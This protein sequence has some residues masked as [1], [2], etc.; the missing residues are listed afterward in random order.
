MNAAADLLIRLRSVLLVVALTLSSVVAHAQVPGAERQV[1]LHLPAQPM[2]QALKGLAQQTG[3]QLLF[4][5]DTGAKE[6]EA[7]ALE[8]TFTLQDAL[9]RLLEGSGL[10]FEFMDENTVAI[11]TER[12]AAES[13]HVLETVNVFATLDNALS[14]GSKSGQSLRETP[15]SVTVVTRERIEAQNLTS[16]AEALAQ[17]TGVT[18]VSHSPSAVDSYF[19]SRGFRVQTLQLDGGAPAYTGGFG[20]YLAPDTAEFDRIEMLRGVDGMFSG[21]GAPGGVVNLVRKRAQAETQLRANVSAGSWNAYRGE[22][23]VTGALTADGK[24]R[25]RLV[26]AYANKDYYY[27]RSESEKTLLFG[28]AEYDLAKA[29]Q[30]IVGASYEDRKEDAY[31]MQ[32][33]PRYSDGR[34]LKLSRSVAFNPDWARR[35]LTSREFFARVEHGYGSTGVV[36]LNLTRLEQSS[37]SRT[38]IAYGFID[39]VTLSGNQAIVRANDY[40]SVQD[41]LDL[42]A[43]GTLALF[44]R[45]HRYTL[46]VDYAQIDGGGEREYRAEGYVFPNG[47]PLDVFNFDPANFPEPVETLTGVYPENGQTQQGVYGALSLKL[48]ESLQL[49]LGGR[50][51]EYRFDQVYRAVAS[52]GT[53]GAPSATR[54]EASKF[55]PSAALHWDFSSRWS[56]YLSYAET[57]EAQ[58]NR[59]RA[60]TPGAVTPNEPID[61]VTG[62]GY[63]IGVKGEWFERLN[64]SFAIYRVERLGQAVED[65]SFASVVSGTDGARCCYVA[66]AD[67]TSRGF[68]AEISGTVVPG[69]QMFAGYTYYT[70]E[71]RGFDQLRSGVL[72]PG[73]IAY[74]LN[75]VPKHMFKM[76]TTWQL[77]GRASR[78]TLNGGVLAQTRNYIDLT[79]VAANGEVVP[80]RSMQGSYAIWNASAQYRLDD[81][82]SIGLYGDNLL[83]K[84]YYQ[85]LGTQTENT[86]GTPRSFMFTARARW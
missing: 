24:L 75:R 49:T 80:F 67:V 36:K 5:S 3:L 50:Y 52:D 76:W 33:H 27:D 8:G 6:V 12:A 45:E 14:V 34:D 35:Y 84:T 53:R 46:G 56:A 65:P 72:V 23:D 59:L 61:P 62:A 71:Y 55:I 29:T 69:W 30:L 38:F 22:V 43:S 74:A 66:A 2:D 11:T 44:G 15:K 73:G 41:L 40:E 32:G 78:W 82:W 28:T 37:E 83:D 58:G 9:R 20:S 25:G 1:E 16:L 47:R 86:Y 68:D 21:V 48:T 64:T 10:A 57:F 79:A 54:Y 26:G 13:V 81:T 85:V 70:N 77:P 4:R 17:T 31:A 18:A 51:S 7:R 42:S 19:Y 60:L 63:E 39:P